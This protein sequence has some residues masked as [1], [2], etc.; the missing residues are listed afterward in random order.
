MIA[1]SLTMLRNGFWSSTAGKASPGRAIITSWLD[2]KE[3]RLEIEKRQE[4]ARMKAIRHELEWVRQKPE[5]A[6]SEEQ[7]ASH[8]V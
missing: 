3:K 4:D 7:G 8:S 2:Q 1:T 5:G 6:P